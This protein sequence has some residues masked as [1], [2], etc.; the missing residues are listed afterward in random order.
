MGKVC[1]SSVLAMSTLAEEQILVEFEQAVDY[2][3]G[4]RIYLESSLKLEIT[5]EM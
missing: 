4:E 1:L 2:K 3:R 5:G